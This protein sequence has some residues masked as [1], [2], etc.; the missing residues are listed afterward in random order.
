VEPGVT[1]LCEHVG[2]SSGKVPPLEVYFIY[3]VQASL[4]TRMI[5]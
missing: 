5:S 1:C 2:Q 3:C 4:I